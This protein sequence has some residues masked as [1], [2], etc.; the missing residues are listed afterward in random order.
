MSETFDV[1]LVQA[2]F[3]QPLYIT[4]VDEKEEDAVL[5]ASDV[6][7][8]K[9][10]SLGGLV[11]LQ[12]QGVDVSVPLG[13]WNG[14]L[15]TARSI[16][17]LGS[18]RGPLR[19][20]LNSMFSRAIP[21]AVPP[22]VLAIV[23]LLEL[24]NERGDYTSP[25]RLPLQR[26]QCSLHVSASASKRHLSNFHGQGLD[27]VRIPIPYVD[28]SHPPIRLWHLDAANIKPLKAAR[29]HLKQ[30]AQVADTPE[31]CDDVTSFVSEKTVFLEESTTMVNAVLKLMI[32][33]I[34]EPVMKVSLA[35]ASCRP[36]EHP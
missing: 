25:V 13:A 5:P 33:K 21:T 8:D 30:H 36:T 15:R 16:A 12:C 9:L 28:A 4:S 29:P 32:S 19:H 10:A 27:G 7:A 14:T 11:S 6:D 23:H 20:D 22:N 31:S 18:I 34:A 24:R 26:G 17:L 2:A 3:N 1:L 35:L